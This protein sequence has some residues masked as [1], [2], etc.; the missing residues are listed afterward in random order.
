MFEVTILTIV[1][2]LSQND[3]DDLLRF[4]S[5]EK[6]ERI[7]RFDFFRD[8]WNCILGDILSRAEI[9]RFT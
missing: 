5:P 6:Q 8:S 9:C 4:V 2:E 3:F 1:S 7:E